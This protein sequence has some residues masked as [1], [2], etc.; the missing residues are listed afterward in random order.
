MLW[1]IALVR[2]PRGAEEMEN[3]RFCLMS[4]VALADNVW[5]TNRRKTL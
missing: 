5:R 4:T 1:L 2:T 3:R